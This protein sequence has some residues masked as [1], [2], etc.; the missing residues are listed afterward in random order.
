[1]SRTSTRYSGLG[2]NARSR[3]ISAG[4]VRVLGL[5]NCTI[6]ADYKESVVKRRSPD[7]ESRPIPEAV[8]ETPAPQ[9]IMQGNPPEPVEPAEPAMLEGTRPTE[10]DE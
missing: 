3:N 2:S 9:V 6:C 7:R 5:A 8:T 4:A 10:V 1:M